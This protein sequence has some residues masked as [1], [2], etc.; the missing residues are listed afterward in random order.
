MNES[1][2]LILILQNIPTNFSVLHI[3]DHQDDNTTY[4][5]LLVY[6]QL[7]VDVDHLAIKNI[8]TL[9]HLYYA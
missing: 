1:E 4:S 8:T 9:N 5:D 6:A 7:N 2:A 3:V